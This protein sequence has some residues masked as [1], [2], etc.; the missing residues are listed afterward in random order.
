MDAPA[1]RV[2]KLERLREAGVEAYPAGHPLLARRKSI[3]EAQRARERWVA[4]AEKD[5]R[6]PEASDGPRVVVAGR[7]V[8]LRDHGNSQFIDVRD[9]S[10]RCQVFVRR[11]DVGQRHFDRLKEGLDLGD[12]VVAA[13]PFGRTRMGEL[14]VFARK[15]A[16]LTKSLA[17][18]PTEWYGL[19]DVEL[20][21]RRRY[22]DLIANEDSRRRF[23]A[24]SGIVTALRRFLDLEGFLEVETPLLHAI[25]GGAAARP[26]I[27]HHN[28]LDLD[29]YLRV[30]PELFLK[31]LLVGGFEKVFEIGRNFRNEGLSP[32]HNPEFT[33]CEA[34]WAY[35]RASDWMD[36][37]QRLLPRL[38]EE[39]GARAEGESGPRVRRGELLLDFTP[40]FA[41]RSFAELL[42]EHA[43]ADLFDRASLQAACAR[44][45]LPDAGRRDEQLADDLFG[46]FVE[47]RLLQPTFVTDFP[48]A[49]S[50]LAKAS[51]EDPRVAERF[52]LY[53]AGM[54]LANAFSELNDPAE[55]LA[56]FE[57]QVAQR[58]PELPAEVDHDYVTALQHGLPP[59]AG[60]G[61]GVD[62]LVMLLTGAESIRDVLLFPLLRPAGGA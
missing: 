13:G 26:F 40:P 30:A 11:K 5:G 22:A 51:P 33:M 21:S 53:V 14:S 27:T 24:R 18:P 20:R 48:I 15:I 43:Q 16:L 39:H 23:R 17:V 34:Y 1:D 31:R 12:I 57:A 7:V 41:R 19:A 2:V 56:R 32:R 46:H 38:A 42:A 35:A 8:A 29:L 58:D 36:G 6:S 62:R 52:E 54:E 10:G 37:L 9:A 59:A 45:G 47:G 60:I 50:P 3:A 44:A 61:I 49:S 4:R 28:A 55:Q 25:A